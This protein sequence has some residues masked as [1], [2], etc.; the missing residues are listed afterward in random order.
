M[1]KKHFIPK[2]NKSFAMRMLFPTISFTLMLSGSLFS[3]NVNTYDYT[4]AAQ[5]FIIASGVTSITV[6]AW[7]AVEDAQNNADSGKKN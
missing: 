7:G 5:N 4:G 2:E 1:T 6:V 3:Q